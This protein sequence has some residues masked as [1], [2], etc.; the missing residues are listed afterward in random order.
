[1]AQEPNQSKRLTMVELALVQEH[2]ADAGLP[3][4][5]TAAIET[6]AGASIVHLNPAT[7]H[8]WLDADADGSPGVVP[9]DG[10]RPPPLTDLF[11]DN[12][13]PTPSINVPLAAPHTPP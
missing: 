13:K 8:T 11:R 1:M 3:H 5:N 12:R 9:V 10:P 4:S 6:L 7:T 2:K